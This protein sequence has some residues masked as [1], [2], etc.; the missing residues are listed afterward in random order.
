MAD[1]Y[2][3]ILKGG[4]VVNHDGEG[5]RDLGIRAGTRYAGKVRDNYTTPD[6]K[7]ILVATDRI[8]A[9]DVVLGT[10]PFH[11]I[12]FVLLAMLV[13]WPEIALWLP[14]HTGSAGP[15]ATPTSPPA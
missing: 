11:L 5:P 2:D 12:M 7:R 8:S 3:L 15:N 4:T 13:F 9:F 14:Q 10:I 1:S 6:G